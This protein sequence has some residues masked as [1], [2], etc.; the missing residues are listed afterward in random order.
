[1]VKK[2]T[3]QELQQKMEKHEDFQLIDVREDFEYEMSNL[4]GKLIPLGRIL[5]EADQIA[6]D[7]PVIVMDRTGRRS[8]AAIEQLE[9]QF[10]YDNLYNLEGGI[11]A[12]SEAI[13]P[14]IQIY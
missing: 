12:W 11:L 7:K 10:G 1:M 6:K 13:D 8:F 3:V 5:T 4:G 14:S 9:Q 2:I